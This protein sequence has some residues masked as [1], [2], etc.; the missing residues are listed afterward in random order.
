[1]TLYYGKHLDLSGETAV[2]DFAHCLVI[3][4]MNHHQHSKKK[5][6]SKSES[7]IEIYFLSY[8]FSASAAYFQADYLELPYEG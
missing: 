4:C 1:M 2:L 6:K 7:Q 3:F 5:K 8:S